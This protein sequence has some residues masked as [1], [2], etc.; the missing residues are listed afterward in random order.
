MANVQSTKCYRLHVGMLQSHVG[1]LQS[2][3]K[4]EQDSM[5]ESDDKASTVH[6]GVTDMSAQ[7]PLTGNAEYCDFNCQ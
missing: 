2:H 5:T 3:V 7:I 4:E 1:M 6:F